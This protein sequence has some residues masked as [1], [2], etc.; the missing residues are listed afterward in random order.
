MNHAL[1]N[2][3][4]AAV[5]DI[6]GD[7]ATKSNKIRRLD[8]LGLARADIARALDIRYQF[9]RNV[10]VED[11]RRRASRQEE[12]VPDGSTPP[13]PVPAAGAGR[14]HITGV[15]RRSAAGPAGHGS[16][17]TGEADPAV[18]A[19]RD[20]P[21][22]GDLGPVRVTLAPGGRLAIPEPF[23]AALGIEDEDDVFLDVEQDEIRIYSRATALRQVQERVAKYVPSDVSLV[24]TL[25][26]ERRREALKEEGGN[27]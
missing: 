17:G 13:N 4:D 25:F 2:A 11:Q 7:D 1:E 27:G 26:A 18:S 23:L 5:R 14:R 10:L 6:V 9:V 3:D 22:A 12:S 19:V 8:K 15:N 16:G 21:S 24:E 20:A